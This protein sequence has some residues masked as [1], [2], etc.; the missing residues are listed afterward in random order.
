MHALAPRRCITQGHDFGVRAACLLG[1]ALTQKLAIGGGENA[2]HTRVGVG[3]GQGAGGL[4]QG[5][6]QGL[7]RGKQ[8]R[9]DCFYHLSIKQSLTSGR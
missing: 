1:V 7:L 2:A 3:F 6:R 8:V 9:H 4:F 5:Q